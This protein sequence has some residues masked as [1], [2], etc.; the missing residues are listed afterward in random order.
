MVAFRYRNMS[1]Q[2]QFVMQHGY[3]VLFLWVLAEQGGLPIPAVPILL[4]AGALSATGHLSLAVSIGLAVLASVLADFVWF[5]FGRHKGMGVLSLLCRMSLEPDSCV[6]QT[7]TAFSNQGERSLLISKFIPGLS[8]AAPPLAAIV[9]VSTPRFLLFDAMG[10]ALWAGSLLLLG[11]VFSA[12]VEMV[13][14]MV[15]SFAGSLATV[16]IVGLTAYIAWKFV[17]RQLFIRELRV[18]RVE[19]AELKAMLDSGAQVVVV[20]LRHPADFA[21]EPRSII[22]ALRMSPEDLDEKYAQIP[23]DHDVIL[24]CT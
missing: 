1:Q 13:T 4:A 12:E 17:K 7:Q 19:P 21:N 24:Y 22:G 9:G 11:Y 14:E 23:R 16:V 20:D 5:Q 8:T 6:R 15:I 10:S 3:T 2:L 18:L